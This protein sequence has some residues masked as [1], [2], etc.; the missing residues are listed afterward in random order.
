MHQMQQYCKSGFWVRYTECKCKQ[1]RKVQFAKRN[2]ERDSVVRL[3]SR[4]KIKILM[5]IA[6]GEIAIFCIR[7]DIIRCSK[8]NSLFTLYACC[9]RVYCKTHPSIYCT[10]RVPLCGKHTKGCKSRDAVPL[11]ELHYCIVNI[12]GVPICFFNCI[13]YNYAILALVYL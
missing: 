9:Y 10:L 12:F 2:I 5:T 3:L 6:W 13:F 1:C 4:F 11:S 8:V 7:K